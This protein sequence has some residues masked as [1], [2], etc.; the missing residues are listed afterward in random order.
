MKKWILAILIGVFVIGMWQMWLIYH[1]ASSYE[2]NLANKAVDKAKNH[3]DLSK[4]KEVTY[5]HGNH[6]Y[7]I[8]EGLLNSGKHVYIWVPD[9]EKGKYFK[10]EVKDGISKKKAIAIF[11]KMH[12]DAAEITTVRLG[13]DDTEPVWEVTFLDS[14]GQYNYVYLYFDNGKEAEHILHI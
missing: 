14:K 1:D 3:Y 2:E 13:I 7:H 8:V 9:S 11:N 6:S 10:R 12:Y 4:V 5:Y